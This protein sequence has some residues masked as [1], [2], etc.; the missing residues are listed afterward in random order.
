MKETFKSN[1][2]WNKK[3]RNFLEYS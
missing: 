2:L 3:W 1:K